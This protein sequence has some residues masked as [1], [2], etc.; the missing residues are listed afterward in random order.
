MLHIEDVKRAD[1]KAAPSMRQRLQGNQFSITCYAMLVLNDGRAFRGHSLGFTT[2]DGHAERSCVR[3]LCDEF[4]IKFIGTTPAQIKNI[5]TAKSVGFRYLYVDFQ[6]CDECDPW[7]EA[8]IGTAVPVY[9]QEE[10]PYQEIKGAEFKKTYAK[11]QK[12]L[13]GAGH[14]DLLNDAVQAAD[15]VAGTLAGEWQQHLLSGINLL[16][17]PVARDLESIQYNAKGEE[18]LISNILSWGGGAEAVAAA[19][20]SALIPRLGNNLQRYTEPVNIVYDGTKNISVNRI[21]AAA[22]QLLIDSDQRLGQYANRYAIQ[23]FG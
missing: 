18:T 4:G 20:L 12:E 15:Q 19:L 13:F 22:M 5:L 6:P 23:P 3:A 16:T 7:L 14:H 2:S 8:L 11:F 17:K 9:F 21:S 10:F 1:P